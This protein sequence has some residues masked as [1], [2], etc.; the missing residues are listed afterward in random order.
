[1]NEF[2]KIFTKVKGFKVLH[3]YAKAHVLFYSLFMFLMIGKSRK[4]L[5]IL[6]NLIQ[7]KILSRLR[8]KYKK[9]VKAFIEMHRFNSDHNDSNIVWV[10]WLQGIESAPSIVRACFESIKR[11]IK[12]KKVI[13]ITK[14]NYSKWINFPDYILLKYSEGKIS[15]THFSDLIRLE[16]LNNYGG[17][18][19]DSTMLCTTEKIPTYMLESNLFIFQTLKPGLDGNPLRVSTCFIH[20]KSHQRILELT[21]FLLLKYWKKNNSLIDYFLIHDFLEI[22]IE[23][24]PDDWD[25][26]YPVSNEEP[27]ILLLRFEKKYDDQFWMDMSRSIPFHKLSYKKK[28]PDENDTYYGR[29]VLPLIKEILDE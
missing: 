24:F 22:A 19:I 23:T 29:V 25:N 6:R 5:E 18:W 12:N 27:H 10:C 2:K 4:K 21:E 8:K 11:N 9:D 17:T 13:L 16:L 7:N 1:M 14:D 15:N 26:V 28:T 20:A 3:N